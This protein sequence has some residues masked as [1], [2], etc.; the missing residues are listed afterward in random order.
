MIRHRVGCVR[1]LQTGAFFDDIT[2]CMQNSPHLGPES[3]ASTTIDFQ[4]GI[5]IWLWYYHCLKSHYKDF[6]WAFKR[7]SPR[8]KWK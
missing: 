5:A 3:D 2:V 8:E 1:M 4:F 7:W 6:Y